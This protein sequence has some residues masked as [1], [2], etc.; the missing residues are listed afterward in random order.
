MASVSISNKVFEKIKERGNWNEIFYYRER[1]L[2]NT[3]SRMYGEPVPSKDMQ[4]NFLD[5]AHRLDDLLDQ[6][7]RQ[8]MARLGQR[9]LIE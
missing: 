2:F 7:E 1:C 6:L 9:R 5:Q 8:E 3:Y 4:E